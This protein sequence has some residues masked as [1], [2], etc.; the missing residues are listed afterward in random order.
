MV[1][2]VTITALLRVEIPGIPVG[3]GRPRAARRK[4]GTGREYVAMLDPEKSVEWKARASYWMNAA[5]VAGGVLGLWSRQL[6]VTVVAY[7]PRPAG[8]RAA[9]HGASPW[10]PSRPDADNLGKAT[11]DAG[12]GVLWADD[13]QVVRL[14]VE[15]RYAP[16]G[17]AP[18]VSVEI[19]EAP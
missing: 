13:A 18:H 8:M 11:L 6:S 4:D 12:N 2:P 9:I 17:K 1:A 16:E 5:R 14:V 19:A 15:K 7:F 3:Q 10:R